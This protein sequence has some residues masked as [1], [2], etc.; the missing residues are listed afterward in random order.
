MRTTEPPLLPSVLLVVAVTL[1]LSLALAQ[2]QE[3]LPGAREGTS[4][5]S[6]EVMLAYME[7]HDPAYFAED[8]EFHV[9]GAGEPFRGREAIGAALATVPM[10]GIYEIRDGQIQV[11]RLYYDIATMMRQLGLM[12]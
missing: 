12:E 7:E 5:G 6:L 10:T 9:M 11:A 2:T 1:A 4:V 3:T 8:A